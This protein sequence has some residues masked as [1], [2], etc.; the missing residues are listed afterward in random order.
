MSGSG[1]SSLLV[2]ATIPIP[3]SGNKQVSELKPSLC[4]PCPTPRCPR[5]VSTIQPSA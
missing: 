2:S 5:K 1:V 4:P 3:S